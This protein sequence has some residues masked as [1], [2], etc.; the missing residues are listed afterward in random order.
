MSLPDALHYCSYLR[1][2]MTAHRFKDATSKIGAYDVF[3][4]QSVARFLIL[5]MGKCWNLDLNE[6]AKRHTVLPNFH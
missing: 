2:S 3:K 4:V 1:N 5:S 6:L